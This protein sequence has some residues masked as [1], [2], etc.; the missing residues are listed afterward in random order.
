MTWNVTSNVA[1]KIFLSGQ[2]TN[3]VGG[4]TWI[5]TGWI[6]PTHHHVSGSSPVCCVE[7]DGTNAPFSTPPTVSNNGGASNV[8]ANSATLYGELTSAGVSA[9][10]VSLFWGTVDCGNT[11]VGWDHAADLG[12]RNVGTLSTNMTGLTQGTTY[13]Y[14][15]YAVNSEGEAWA[16]PAAQF[17]TIGAP[18]VNNSSGAT[19]ILSASARL[20]GNLIAG[21]SADVTVYWGTADGG[22][23]AGSWQH[24]SSL[25]TL[26]QGAFFCDIG[27]LTSNTTYHYRCYATNTAGTAWAG[28]TASFQTT[29]LLAGVITWGS[30]TA[31]AG[32]SD[33]ITNGTLLYATSFGSG[34]TTVNTV[35][36]AGE[37]NTGNATPQ[38]TGSGPGSNWT[39]DFTSQWDGL[40]VGTAP[41]GNLS[42][43]Y[44]NMFAGGIYGNSSNT[45]TLQKLTVGQAYQVQIWCVNER[46]ADSGRLTL[47]GGGG[48]SVTLKHNIT[49]T[50]GGLGQYAVGIFVANGSSQTITCTGAVMVSALQLRTWD[51]GGG[52][53]NSP[54][55][56]KTVQRGTSPGLRFTWDAPVNPGVTNIFRI[57]RMTNLLAGSWQI[58]ASNI[59]SSATNAWSDTNLFQYA[60]Y[61]VTS[62]SQ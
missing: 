56:F 53:V 34:G 62:L 44:K 7:A 57:Y 22:T 45:I 23:T 41:F 37:H 51:G 15:F 60:F 19:N 46:D 48:N 10:S 12:Q 16:S 11:T 54:P 21:S 9:T 58:V 28:S 1:D 18:A 25:G 50:A 33:V 42:S 32:D 26:S 30:A 17:S 2:T 4:G 13:Y 59:L 52:P 3:V 47:S 40:L 31:I 43:N 14:R 27:A 55:E 39:S 49:A 35:A 24:T 29:A 8:T 38:P 20:T 61:R 6:T 5:A 36:F